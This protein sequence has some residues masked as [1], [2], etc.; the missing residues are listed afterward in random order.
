MDL[1]RNFPCGFKEGEK[2][3]AFPASERE[4]KAIMNYIQSLS[5]I[6]SAIHYHSSGEEIY[7]DY[8]VEG[9]LR[10]QLIKLANIYE[11]QTGYRAVKGTEDTIPNGGLGEW[12]VHEKGIP[13][14]TIETGKRPCPLGWWEWYFLKHC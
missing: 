9:K 13:S 10:G 1:N 11:Q 14:I 4:T 3:G 12:C 8:H 2:N 6:R 5:N 7:Y